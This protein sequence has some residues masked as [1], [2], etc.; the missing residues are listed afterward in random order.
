[1]SVLKMSIVKFI[2]VVGLTQSIAICHCYIATVLLQNIGDIK[3]VQIAS[4][5]H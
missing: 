2:I 1:L 4:V 5:L 3:I